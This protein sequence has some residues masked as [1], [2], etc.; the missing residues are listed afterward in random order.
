MDGRQPL[1]LRERRLDGASSGTAPRRL[2][3]AMCVKSASISE[4]AWRG[5]AKH[6]FQLVRIVGSRFGLRCG[7]S[8]LRRLGLNRMVDFGV[9]GAL[10]RPS[11]LT[12]ASSAVHTT[13]G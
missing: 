13:Q 9:L 1:M 12:M 2:C 7:S 4:S 11:G 6:Q 8:S 10:C 5:I 3:R